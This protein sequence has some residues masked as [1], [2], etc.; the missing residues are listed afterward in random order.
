MTDNP[1]RLFLQN[2][3]AICAKGVG[4]LPSGARNSFGAWCD[5]LR[6]EIDSSGLPDSLAGALADLD[7]QSQSVALVLR[8]ELDFVLALQTSVLGSRS[9]DDGRLATRD[10]K[11]AIGASKS[12]L[13]SLRELFPGLPFWAKCLL[14]VLEE[15]HEIVES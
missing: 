4:R 12:L 9:R 14:K 2:A 10:G 8:A 6:Q 7:S 5:S 11:R 15:L 13:G 1:F 3:V